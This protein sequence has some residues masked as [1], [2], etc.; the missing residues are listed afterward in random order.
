[1]WAAI[2]C[3]CMISR[4]HWLSAMLT[5]APMSQARRRGWTSEPSAGS[6]SIPIGRK[7]KESSGRLGRKPPSVPGAAQLCFG[8]GARRRGIADT[9]FLSRFLHGRTVQLGQVI[10]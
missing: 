8:G 1:M 7:A 10:R 6:E 5:S 9:A 3:A 2:R 4:A